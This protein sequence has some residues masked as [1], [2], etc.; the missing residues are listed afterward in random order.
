MFINYSCRWGIRD[1]FC[2]KVTASLSQRNMELVDRDNKILVSGCDI[3]G[4]ARGKILNS[5][6]FKHIENGFGFCNVIFG[7]DCHDAV[8]E[9]KTPGMINDPGFA[10]ILAKVDLSTFRRCPLSGTPHYVVEFFNP[11]TQ[12]PLPYCPRSLLRKSLSIMPEYTC[13]TGVEFEFFNYKETSDSLH[14]KKGTNLTPLTTGMFG[15]SLARPAV[16]QDYFD[17]IYNGALAFKI[18]LECYH[19]ETGLLLVFLNQ[20]MTIYKGPGVYEAAIEYADTLEL[21]DRAHLFKLLTKKIGAKRKIIGNQA[22]LL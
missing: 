14:A 22:Y 15:Y 18:P 16:Y 3:D 9:P 19:T 12:Q 21:C 4:I 5:S 13:L 11:L 20:L 7:W 8:Y 2:N 17:E 6:K 1:Q 10:D